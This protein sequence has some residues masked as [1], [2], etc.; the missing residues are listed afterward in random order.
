MTGRRN[1]G[2]IWMSHRPPKPRYTFS[3]S[4]TFRARSADI[5]NCV[6]GWTSF[7]QVRAQ[8]ARINFPCAGSNMNLVNPP[9]PRPVLSQ[10]ALCEDSGP[11]GPR[12]PKIAHIC[13]Q[14]TPILLKHEAQHAPGHASCTQ[15]FGG[16]HERNLLE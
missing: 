6:E 3:S 7:T 15:G 2:D 9:I 10:V 13:L 8:P 5:F 11:A 14:F 16:H 1:K 12:W 4:V